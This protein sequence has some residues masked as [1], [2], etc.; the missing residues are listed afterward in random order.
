MLTL[1]KEFARS[2]RE[3]AT[4]PRL[5]LERAVLGLQPRLLRKYDAITTL[6]L[7]TGALTRWSMPGVQDLVSPLASAEQAA[8]TLVL[9][10][11][12]ASGLDAPTESSSEY[13]GDFLRKLG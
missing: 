13:D 6:R 10:A 12:R 8:M 4:F 7:Q 9:H 5:S 2:A 11:S 3:Q 1:A